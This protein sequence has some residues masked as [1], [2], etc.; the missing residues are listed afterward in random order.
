MLDAQGNLG[1]VPGTMKAYHLGGSA[2]ATTPALAQLLVLNKGVIKQVNFNCGI[3]L[4]TDDSSITIEV[5]TIP[6]AGARVNGLNG[7]VA[8]LS[9]FCNLVT[10]GL[11]NTDG[12]VCVP[13]NYPVEAGSTIYLHVT[14]TGTAGVGID[15][16]VFVS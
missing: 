8:M 3:N 4:S 10:S 12:N 6:S 14:I 9:Y 1:T 13:V 2:T 15:A 16:M 5:S 7:P 11:S